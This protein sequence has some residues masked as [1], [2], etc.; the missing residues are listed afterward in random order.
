MTAGPFFGGRYLLSGVL[1]NNGIA[2]AVR[3]RILC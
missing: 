2:I 3:Q 1:A